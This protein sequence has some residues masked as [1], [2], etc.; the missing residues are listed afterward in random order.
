[1]PGCHRDDSGDARACANRLSRL[2]R[3]PRD[4]HDE[5][6]CQPGRQVILQPTSMGVA[7]QSEAP[8]GGIGGVKELPKGRL[9]GGPADLL[10]A[11]HDHQLPPAEAAAEPIPTVSFGRCIHISAELLPVG[12][13]AGKALGSGPVSEICQQGTRGR[14]SDHAE[15]T[16]RN[17]WCGF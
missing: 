14:G 2:G 1:M 4:R 17:A 3:L 9:V 8:V 11:L 16:P 10:E 12:G 13:E 15:R 5:A 7:A 6:G